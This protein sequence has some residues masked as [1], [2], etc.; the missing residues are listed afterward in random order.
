VQWVVWWRRRRRLRLLVNVLLWRGRMRDTPPFGCRGGRLS[1]VSRDLE[2]V[3]QQLGV[4]DAIVGRFYGVMVHTHARVRHVLD[5]V[6]PAGDVAGGRAVVVV[7]VGRRGVVELGAGALCGTG[8]DERGRGGTA[9]FVEGRG[10]NVGRAGAL[11]GRRRS[12]GSSSVGEGLDGGAQ[13]PGRGRQDVGVWLLEV[14][15]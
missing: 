13:G 5:I 4:G 7:G 11:D 2:E 3:E 14:W 10:L 1:G 15:V 12:G 9:V 8:V 6:G